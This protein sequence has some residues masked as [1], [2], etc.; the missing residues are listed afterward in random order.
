MKKTTSKS[1]V[2]SKP[3]SHNS[4]LRKKAEQ[5][6]RRKN[7]ADKDLSALETKKLIHELQ[8]HQIE[9]EM[10]NEELRNSQILLEESRSKNADLYDFAPVGYFSMDKNWN[11]LEVNLT[12]VLQLGIERS[13]LINKPFTLFIHKDDQDIFYIHRR[14]VLESNTLQSCEVRLKQKKGPEF[15]AKIISVAS[16][17]AEG[18]FKQVRTSVVNITANKIAQEK[19]NKADE[20]IKKLSSIGRLATDLAHEL[21][22][23]LA[24]LLLLFEKQLANT[25]KASN[26]Y[27]AL[28]LMFDSAKHMAIVLSKF[29][30]FL[31]ESTGEFTRINIKHIIES[32]LILGHEQIAAE[33][34]DII[35]DYG[36]NIPD[37][38][39]NMT[40]LQIV[41]LNIITNAC[42]AMDNDGK[43]IIKVTAD[44]DM[45]AVNIEFTDNGPG[46]DKDTLTRIFDPSFSTKIPGKG[47]GL[48]LPV[49]SS[50]I[51][52]HKGKITVISEPGKGTTFQISLPSI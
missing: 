40:E 52:N 49:S 6:L 11:I 46:I 47:T 39:G 15:C 31:S 50:I 35:K 20:D 33:S 28:D 25:K 27:K 36:D 22:S 32:I 26:G 10:Q 18:D 29:S 34:I 37:V 24:E 19:L 14:A 51:K 42:D 16:F 38:I 3:K 17:D 12:G 23:P 1:K 7:G 30:S 41:I 5:K 45:K 43:L 2:S 13:S 8:V 21:N 9:L 44:N 4:D 48:G